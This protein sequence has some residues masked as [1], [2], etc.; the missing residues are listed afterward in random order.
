VALRPGVL[1]RDRPI[2]ERPRRCLP[3]LYPVPSG[4]SPS[5]MFPRLRPFRR[6]GYVSCGRPDESQVLLQLGAIPGG[7]EHLFGFGVGV[8]RGF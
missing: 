7:Q 6:A 1:Q 4:V 2:P 5:V 3:S 8:V